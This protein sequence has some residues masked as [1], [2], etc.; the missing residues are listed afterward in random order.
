MQ[1]VEGL[2]SKLWGQGLKMLGQKGLVFTASRVI[3]DMRNWCSTHLCIELYTFMYG[4]T[5]FKHIIL[6]LV[7]N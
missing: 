3:G 6:I 1:E 2:G 5:A 4:D 7:F